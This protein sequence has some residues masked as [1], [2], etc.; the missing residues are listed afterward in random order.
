M[1]KKKREVDEM[2]ALPVALSIRGVI[3][4]DFI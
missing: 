2:L 3:Y 4:L 1:K